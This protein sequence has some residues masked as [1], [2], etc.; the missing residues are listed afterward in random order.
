MAKVIIK[1]LITNNLKYLFSLDKARLP[2]QKKLLH[3]GGFKQYMSQAVFQ[4]GRLQHFL[5]LFGSL[6]YRGIVFLEQ[7]GYLRFRQAYQQ[8]AAQLEIVSCEFGA[9]GFQ[10]GPE[11]GAMPFHGLGQRLLVPCADSQVCIV[12]RFVGGDDFGFSKALSQIEAD[13]L[14]HEGLIG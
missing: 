1:E 5:Y 14:F 12:R 4:F 10:Q 8:E 6:P 7:D 3:R 9:S 11:V 13:G 2:K